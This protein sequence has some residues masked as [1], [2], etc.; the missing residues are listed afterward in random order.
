MTM[1]SKIDQL[2]R[3]DH[4]YL[5]EDDECYFHGEY[6]PREGFEYSNTNSFVLNLKKPVC[7]RGTPEWHHKEKAIIRASR[8][9]REGFTDEWLK[10][11]VL[12]PVPPSKVATDPAYD[13]RMIRVLNN[14]YPNK[15]LDIRELV[16]QLVNRE[17]MHQLEDRYKPS[18]LMEM[19]QIKE[20]SSTPAPTSIGIFDDVLTSGTHFCAMKT[21]LQNRFPGV[22]VIGIFLARVVRPSETFDLS[23]LFGLSEP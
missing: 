17:A 6:T 16:Q 22:E 20:D 9:I 2:T 4:Y 8:L 11:A 5:T 15:N 19:W 23:E 10:L 3:G 1:F 13:D 12:V 14:I 7:R 21:I 18:E